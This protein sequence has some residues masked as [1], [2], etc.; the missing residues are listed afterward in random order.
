MDEH[1]HAATTHSSKADTSKS[2]S[3]GKDLHIESSQKLN[4]WLHTFMA[5]RG[6]YKAVVRRIPAFL[7]KNEFYL[8]LNVSLP[9]N[10][11][12]FCQGGSQAPSAVALT[13]WTHSLS[14]ATSSSS[15]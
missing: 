3:S 14:Q 1:H 12:Y 5:S 8:G 10:Q 13:A 4:M 2:K 7:S 15:S 9:V 6:L 11:W